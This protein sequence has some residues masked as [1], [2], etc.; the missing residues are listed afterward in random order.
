MIQHRLQRRRQIRL[1]QPRRH[2]QQQRL[3][4]PLERPAALAQAS[5]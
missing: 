2:L 4:E 3:A 5:A 1:P